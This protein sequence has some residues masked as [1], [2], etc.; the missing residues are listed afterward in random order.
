MNEKIAIY[1]EKYGEI[2]YGKLL[3]ERKRFV[4]M[5]HCSKVRPLLLIRCSI[6]YETVLGYIAAIEAHIPII[7]CDDKSCES[8]INTYAPQY[9]WQMKDALSPYGY[10]KCG[11]MY[12]YILYC[13]ISASEYLINDE[14]ALMLSTSGSTGST[15]YVRISYDNIKQNTISIVKALKIIDKDRAGV[16]LPLSYTYGLSIVNTYLYV[17]ASLIIGASSIIQK[18]LWEYFEKCGGNAICGVPYTYEIIKKMNILLRPDLHLKLATQA[19]GRLDFE[20][21][22]YML[23]KSL[24]KKFDFAVMYGQTEATARMTCHFLNENPQY[25]GSVGKAIPGGRIYV[26][27]DE[28]VYTGPNVT[29]GYA[30]CGEDLNLGDMNKGVL[31][32]GDLGRIDETGYVYITGRKNRIAKIAGQRINLD[33]LENLIEHYIGRRSVCVEKKKYIK[34]LVVGDD[35]CIA[36]KIENDISQMTGLNKRFISVLVNSSIPINSNGKVDYRK[37]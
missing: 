35:N 21:E 32:T 9:I 27:N 29:M 25:I 34:I 30:T 16:F 11:V 37:V 23:N 1:S 28:I 19:G 13:R 10:D 3:L 6:S 7:M 18:G 31:Y 22:K 14:L 33:E 24:D 2:T 17:G 5:F 8:A 26:D 36:S 15:K 12:G 4:S 20:T